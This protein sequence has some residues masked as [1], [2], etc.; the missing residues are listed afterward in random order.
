ME[1]AA[2]L[3]VLEQQRLYLMSGLSRTR[4]IIDGIHAK[5]ASVEQSL[6]S[7]EKLQRAKKKKLQHTRWRVKTTLR[8]CENE[9]HALFQNLR[10][11]EER[12]WQL[13]AAMYPAYS[14]AQLAM[15]YTSPL[16]PWFSTQ[17]IDPGW[18]EQAQQLIRPDAPVSAQLANLSLTEP[19][20]NSLASATWQW[21][22]V[23]WQP[24]DSHASHSQLHSFPSVSLDPHDIGS[25]GPIECIDDTGTTHYIYNS[26]SGSS[27][28]DS[29]AGTRQSLEVLR[30]TPNA[31]VFRPEAGVNVPLYS[32]NAVLSASSRDPPEPSTS[33]SGDTATT[34]NNSLSQQAGQT[35]PAH[36]S[37]SA[38]K[39]SD[40][41]EPDDKSG[42]GEDEEPARRYSAAAVDLLLYRFSHPDP[43]KAK[44]GSKGHAHR[45]ARSSL[46]NIDAAAVFGIKATGD[47]AEEVPEEAEEVAASQTVPPLSA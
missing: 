33:G 22:S 6:Q 18:V 44:R 47:R 13:Q 37:P 20:G 32:P 43:T 4:I 30:P 25:P 41:G 31:L 9:Q 3:A 21:P 46:G 5:L 45:K 7:P 14:N 10:A 38:A 39:A 40:A 15:G 29:A 26:R 35:R 11:C 36:P 1:T 19:Y 42:A 24:E 17:T 12:I 8:N 23:Q 16:Q 28:K 34:T 2:T 27:N